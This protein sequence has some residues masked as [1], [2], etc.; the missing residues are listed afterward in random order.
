MVVVRLKERQKT[1]MNIFI[2]IEE[3]IFTVPDEEPPVDGIFVVEGQKPL[4]LVS[5]SIRVVCFLTFILSGG[6]RLLC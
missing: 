4:L 2:S 1:N 6:R 5:L 3:V